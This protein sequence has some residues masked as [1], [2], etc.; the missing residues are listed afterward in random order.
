MNVE[1]QRINISENYFK[2]NIY[3]LILDGMITEMDKCFMN[4]EDL[5][6][7]ISGFNPNSI[8]F[9]NYDVIVL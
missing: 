4:N 5:L 3:N 1:K 7:G 6:S 9:L 2:I 8:Q